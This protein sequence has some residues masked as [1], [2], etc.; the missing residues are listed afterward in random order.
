M[1]KMMRQHYIPRLYLKNFSYKNKDTYHT[2]ARKKG[3]TSVFKTNIENIAA[4]N[5]FYTVDSLADTNEWEKFYA[6]MV[7]PHFNACLTRIIA[8]CSNV[9]LVDEVKLLSDQDKQDLAVNM[10]IQIMRGKV[11]REKSKE[12][13]E[14]IAPE[15]ISEI[16]TAKFNCTQKY[17]QDIISREDCFKNTV[18]QAAVNPKHILN[19]ANALY[20]KN[21][22]LLQINGKD[23][24]ITSDSPIMAINL[25]SLDVTPFKNGI[26]SN[27]TGISFPIAHHIL[28]MLY[29]HTH[30]G[31]FD[32][33]DSFRIKL[34]PTTEENFIH[35]INR[36]QYKQ[37][38]KFVMAKEESTLLNL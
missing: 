13:Y 38:N 11:H 2:F 20:N 9:L 23:G 18:Y 5:N 26:T 24:F 7:E 30:F 19:I 29:P 31:Y 6:N 10:A 35:T 22:I 17:L 36:L 28:L 8:K 33:K 1:S 25:K 32:K 12:L 14:R 27:D 16:D 15:V 21:W 3:S 4:E 37:C 34:D